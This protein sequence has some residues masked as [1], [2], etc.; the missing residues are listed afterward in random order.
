MVLGYRLPAPEHSTMMLRRCDSLRPDNWLGRRPA[1]SYYLNTLAVYPEYQKLGLGGLLLATAEAQA[2][3]A[4]CSC[5]ILETAHGNE[6]ALRF[7]RRN[8]FVAWAAD[9]GGMAE[10]DEAAGEYCV[11]GKWLPGERPPHGDR[12]AATALFP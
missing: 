11:L 4:G 8:G 3:R 2:R 12:R 10:P 5:L 9:G 6:S 7:Y 1:S